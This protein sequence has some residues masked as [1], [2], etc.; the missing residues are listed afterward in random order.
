M[1]RAKPIPTTNGT[2]QTQAVSI[3][4]VHVDPANIRQHPEVNRATIRASLARFGPG[5]SIVL[6]VN[7]VVRAGNGT[8]EEARQAGFD[9]V[10]VVEPK[11]NQLVAVKRADWSATEATAYGIADNR[12]TDLGSFDDSALASTL[13]ALQDDAFDLGAVGYSSDELEDLLS[14]LAD[15]AESP[16]PADPGP[17]IDR[18]DELQK[19]WGTATGQLWLIP[20]KTASGE[21]RLLCGDSTKPDDVARA[22]GGQVQ[23]CV[24]SPPYWGLRDYGTATW[25]GGDPECDHKKP[26][27]TK[28][29]GNPEF[30]ENRPS[31]EATDTVGYRDICGKCGATRID[32]QVG[33]EATPEAYTARMVALFALVQ[34]V[35]RDDGT[36]WVNIGDSYAGGGKGNYGS[37][38]STHGGTV[39]KHPNGSDFKYP[40]LKPKD[41][42]G[43][44]WRIA[45]ALQADGWYL[46]QD[47]IWDKGN[48]MPESVQDRCCKSHEYMFLLSKRPRYY[49]D[50]EA[51]KEAASG[52]ENLQSM[53]PGITDDFFCQE[54]STEG[55]SDGEVSELSF[56]SS[57]SME[58]EVQQDRKGQGNGSQVLPFC[59]G[60]EDQEGISSNLPRDGR[61]EGAVSN[62]CQK[63]R[64]GGSVQGSH[65]PLLAEREREGC[66]GRQGQE[67]SENREGDLR[68]TEGG[69]QAQ[70]SD[71]NIRL[72]ADLSPVAGNQRAVRERLRV[73]PEASRSSGKGSCNPSVKGREA[74]KGKRSSSLPNL[75]CTKGQPPTRIKRSVWHI[76]SE[77][78]PGSHFAT[79]PRKLIEPCI[80]AGTSEKGACPTCG[81]PW[82][83]VT[84]PTEEYQALID[85]QRGK[86][87]VHGSGYADSIA[88]GRR[89]TA[90]GKQGRVQKTTVHLGF[91]QSC[92]CPS[93]EPVP[94]TVFDPFMGAATTIVACEQAG[95]LGRGIELS[96]QYVAI[97]LERL[98]GMGLCPSLQAGG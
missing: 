2:P 9:E 55:W 56:D 31:R 18:A 28:L 60:A 59:E 78:F 81:A 68:Q 5:R 52:S 82:E 73:L 11:A 65:A 48:P 12:A 54:Q 20:S 21:H 58:S 77:A 37:G 76:N 25:E 92:K 24:T 30:N 50:S 39:E 90:I 34:S 95:R 57:E 49:F 45:F 29:F 3:D 1:A 53:Q 42:V 36:C 89:D 40:G 27:A 79:Y 8:L 62:R 4:D 32:A 7:N 84:E 14:D 17:Q 10:L 38:I 66:E 64:E 74:H 85:S 83:R 51:I 23:M 97:A 94:C 93:A 33:L 47:I 16:P 43:I 63:T 67:V 71:Q 13:K 61:T 80:A 70:V 35:L 26:G 46:R 69:D 19:K 6:D 87:H 41:L 75:Q 15:D 96:P 22:C 98:E 91:R 88:N 72:H 44:P 86:N